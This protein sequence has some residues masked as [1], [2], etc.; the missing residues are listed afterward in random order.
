MQKPI[1]PTIDLVIQKMHQGLV[2]TASELRDNQGQLRGS[3][4]LQ[5]IQEAWVESIA[6]YADLTGNTHRLDSRINT[7]KEDLVRALGGDD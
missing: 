3:T 4:A 5:P 7:V 1:I 2:E 6:M